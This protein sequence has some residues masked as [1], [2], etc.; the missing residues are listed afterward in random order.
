MKFGPL[1]LLET[2]GGILA[3][4]MRL[5]N[6]KRLRKGLVIDDETIALLDDAGVQSITV[7]MPEPGDVLEDDAATRIAKAMD[8][9]GLRSEPASTGRVNIFAE[10]NGVFRVSVAKV[11]ALNAVD[12]GITF[13]TLPDFAAVNEGRLVA[14]IKIIPYAVS[15]SA[16]A[17]VLSHDLAGTISLAA[18]EKKRVGVI[19]TTLPALKESIL[20]K[21]L[22]NLEA[23]LSL[24][25]SEIV[26]ELRVPHDEQ[27]ICECN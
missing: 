3:H 6:G 15:G 7:A 14:T 23:R 27:A 19:S 20:V 12:P 18:F 4:S 5:E 21:T 9:S 11:D 26:E 8:V 17:D 1:P 25:A 16:L 22:A 24:S 13:A 2:K 10:F